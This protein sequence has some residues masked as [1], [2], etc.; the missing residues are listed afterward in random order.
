MPRRLSVSHYSVPRGGAQRA[1]DYLDSFPQA[2]SDSLQLRLRPSWKNA[3]HRSFVGAATGAASSHVASGS[4]RRA[5]ERQ[6][7]CASPWGF[8][9]VVDARRPVFKLTRPG[10]TRVVT[11]ELHPP[12]HIRESVGIIQSARKE[13]EVEQMQHGRFHHRSVHRHRFNAVSKQ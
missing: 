10:P 5:V 1:Y 9:D 11:L 7:I 8:W 2:M 12:L 4:K 13:I 3:A 6:V